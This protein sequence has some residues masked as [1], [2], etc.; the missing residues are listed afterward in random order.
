VQ[1]E[2]DIQRERDRIDDARN[3]LKALPRRLSESQLNRRRELEHKSIHVRYS[4]QPAKP[5]PKPKPDEDAE[6]AY[7]LVPSMSAGDDEEV[8]SD[9][10]EEVVTE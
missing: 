6:A 3:A 8:V 1:D 7:N 5:K 10:G 4:R 2:A 9:D